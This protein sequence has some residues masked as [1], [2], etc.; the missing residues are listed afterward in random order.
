M[1]IN[2]F[3]IHSHVNFPEYDADRA[4]VLTR[5]KEKGVWTIT[6]GTNFEFSQSAVEMADKNEGIFATIGLHPAGAEPGQLA[7]TF[8]ENAFAELVV[9]PK[10]V[11]IGEC[12]MDYGRTDTATAEDKIR[13]KKDFETQIDFAVR[14]NKPLMLHIRNAHEDV[15]DILTFKKREYGDKLRGNVHFFSG[16]I[17]VEKKYLELGFSVSFTGVITFVKD[18]HEAVAYAP[19]DMLMSETDAPYVTP[20]PY[21]GKRNEPVYVEEVVKKMA[22]IKGKSVEEMQKILVDNA[23]RIFNIPL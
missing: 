18:Y 17:E 1:H 10:V 19:L 11:A 16:T 9:H 8:D 12:G 22:E 15:L 23:I 20:I 7:E 13:Q 21:R 14:Y 5:M 4:E 2:F 6:V 3:D